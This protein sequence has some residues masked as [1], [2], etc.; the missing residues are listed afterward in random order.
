VFYADCGSAAVEV[1]LKM[2]F[3]FWKQTGR[4][5]KKRFVSLSG[6]YHGETLGALSVGGIPLYRELF[7]PLML[8]TV[9]VRGPECCRCPHGLERATCAAECFAPMA[10]A[11]EEH[12]PSLAAVFI[13]PMVQCANGMNM[14]SPAYLRKL[15]AA[16]TAHTIHLVADEIAVGFG[17]TGRMFACEHAGIA[18]DFTCMSKGLTGGYLPFAAVVVRDEAVFDAFLGEYHD[19]KAFY[20]SHSYTGNPLACKV[21]LEALDVLETE[22][23]PTLPDQIAVLGG[24][25]DRLRALPHVESV[26]QCGFIGAADLVEDRASRRA[27][28]PSRRM[29][30]NVYRRALERGAVLRPLGDTVYFLPPLTIPSPVLEELGEIAYNSIQ[31]V[32]GP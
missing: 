4:P 20:H 17:R 19:Y 14:Y 16:C 6:A 32:T 23:M 10:R 2:S 3:Q 22:V 21:A 25:L 26:R 24:V 27:Y 7:A 28:D 11:L 13:E 31:D 12:A 9:A 29:G 30:W 15:R 8:D 5:D 1:A 18:P